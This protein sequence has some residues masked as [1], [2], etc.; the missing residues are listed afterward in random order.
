MR[1]GLGGNSSSGDR[2]VQQETPVVVAEGEVRTKDS[3]LVLSRGCTSSRP[4]EAGCLLTVHRRD[5]IAERWRGR[6]CGSSEAPPW[7]HP[8][9]VL[10]EPTSRGESG[11]RGSSSRGGLRGGDRP[12]VDFQNG[13]AGDSRVRGCSCVVSTSRRSSHGTS[14]SAVGTS[15]VVRR[16][17]CRVRD[18]ATTR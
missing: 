1:G 11:V 18:P 4:S 8:L 5:T 13:S 9:A 10:R 7:T 16:E 15:A 12:S 17:Q 14:P 6:G 3:T 2:K